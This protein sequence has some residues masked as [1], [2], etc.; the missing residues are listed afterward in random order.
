MFDQEI[1]TLFKDMI[2][3]VFTYIDILEISHYFPLDNG[4]Q[5]YYNRD[6]YADKV[7][8]T[9]LDVIAFTYKRKQ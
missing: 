9:M 6:G 2:K 5:V 7:H 3:S 4:Y 8:F 1:Y